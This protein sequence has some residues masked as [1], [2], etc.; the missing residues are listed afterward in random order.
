[1]QKNEGKWRFCLQDSGNNMSIVLGLCLGSGVMTSDVRLD[2]HSHEIRLLIKVC[3][4]DVTDR[5]FK[6]IISD[7]S[8][9]SRASCFSL[10]YPR[11]CVQSVAMLRDPR[12]QEIWW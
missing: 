2:V 12:R 7:A 1:M 10:N 3:D 6:V 11:R 8:L 5:Y 9:S 4:F